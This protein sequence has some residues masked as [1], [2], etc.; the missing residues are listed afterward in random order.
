M[1]LYV[2]LIG[3][4]ILH[5]L[6]H[7]RRS[8]S[9]DSMHLDISFCVRD[10]A[11]NQYWMSVILRHLGSTAIKTGPVLSYIFRASTADADSRSCGQKVVKAC[12]GSN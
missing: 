12:L 1:F 8:V 4:H 10:A 9:K 3:L 11:E 5:H 7:I 6:Q 2:K